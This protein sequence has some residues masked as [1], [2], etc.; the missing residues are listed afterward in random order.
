MPFHMSET[1]EQN[2]SHHVEEIESFLLR[3]LS[4]RKMTVR[5]HLMKGCTA[6]FHC[7]KNAT[8]DFREYPV[9]KA[10]TLKKLSLSLQNGGT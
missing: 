5:L 7:C 2:R 6:S 3:Q 1:P 4:F 8:S 9:F 10:F